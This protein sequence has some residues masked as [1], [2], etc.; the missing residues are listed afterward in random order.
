MAL[1]AM[2]FWLPFNTSV[3]AQTSPPQS[4][5]TRTVRIVVPLAAGGGADVFARLLAHEFQTKYDQPFVIENRP[6]GNLNI[7]ARA[8]AESPPDGYTLCLLPSD[9]IVYNQFL[10]RSLPFNP[11]KDFE[12]I[13]N[14][15]FNLE[16]VVVSAQL[17]VE[18]IPELVALAKDKP[19]TLSYGTFSFVASQFMNKLWKKYDVNIVRVPFRSG[20][21]VVNA[22]LSST[23]PIALLGLSNML[24]QIRAGEINGLALSANA[25][26][27]LFPNMPTLQE[28]TGEDYPQTWFG[29]FAPAGTPK[30][31]IDQVYTDTAQITGDPAFRQKN[32]ADR[33]IEYGVS[34][35]EQFAS[36][37]VRARAEAELIVKE[38]GTQP[39]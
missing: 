28:A 20:N 36:F 33:A 29:L 24:S 15:F 19:G 22:V 26:S 34:T 14:L 18:T 23:T 27:P 4:W 31:I 6:G 7:G 2:A 13:A 8:C 1:L 11:E 16:A 39:Q 35:P 9:P 30:P 10:Y 37:I 17:K 25:R 3:T 32:Y 12:P 21:E 5:P 38:S